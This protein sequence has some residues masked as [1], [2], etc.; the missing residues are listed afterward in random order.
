LI[1]P[2]EINAILLVVTPGLVGEKEAILLVVTPPGLAEERDVAP[3][4]ITPGL[5]VTFGSSMMFNG[6][7]TWVEASTASDFVFLQGTSRVSERTYSI[8]YIKHRHAKL[9]FLFF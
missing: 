5:D 7:V 8:T 6:S 2:C 9:L 3:L 4:F 1:P